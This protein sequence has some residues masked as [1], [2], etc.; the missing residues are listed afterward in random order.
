MAPWVRSGQR[1][2]AM[3][4]LVSISCRARPTT[5]GKPP[6]PELLREGQR[7]PAGVDELL[8][9]RFERARGG[10]GGIRI[11]HRADG[12]A[13]PVG[14]RDDLGDEVA[15]LGQQSGHGVEVGMLEAGQPGELVVADDVL[16]DEGQ[17][18]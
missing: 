15:R 17:V 3:F 2:N 18:G 11:A 13:D 4:A 1:A 9:C 12:V 5:D 10:D 6:P 16:E 7:R 8:V 14:G